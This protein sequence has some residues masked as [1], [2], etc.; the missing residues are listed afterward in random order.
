MIG[1][2]VRFEY[3]KE[4]EIAFTGRGRVDLHDTCMIVSGPVLRFRLPFFNPIFEGLLTTPSYRTIPYGAVERYWVSYTLRRRST[5]RGFFRPMHT[6]KFRYPSGK[7]AML[8][9][10]VSGRGDR[11]SAFPASLEEYLTATRSLTAR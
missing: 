4:P 6:V 11:A 9:F 10:T 7:D 8:S 3:N 5:L 1:V 2:D